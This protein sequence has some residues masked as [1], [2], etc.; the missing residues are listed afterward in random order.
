MVKY[1]EKYT[2]TQTEKNATLTP[3]LWARVACTATL[4]QVVGQV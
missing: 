3:P 4:A 1:F 2:K